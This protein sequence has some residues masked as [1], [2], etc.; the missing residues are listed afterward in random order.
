M[1]GLQPV[2]RSLEGGRPR[3]RAAEVDGLPGRGKGE[4]ARGSFLEIRPLKLS[5][6]DAL[7][8]GQQGTIYRDEGT[9]DT[10][11]MLTGRNIN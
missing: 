4:G 7:L 11:L 10:R 9:G 1:P 6:P 5:L 3:R 8:G 2:P